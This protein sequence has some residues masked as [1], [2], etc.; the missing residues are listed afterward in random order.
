MSSEPVPHAAVEPAEAEDA[1]VTSRAGK[2]T[3]GAF[4]GYDRLL[5]GFDAGSAGFGVSAYSGYQLNAAWGIEGVIGF[6]SMR[7][8]WIGLLSHA[9][10]DKYVPVGI[11]GR[12]TIGSGI[13]KLILSSHVGVS[14]YYLNIEP[15]G[16][17]VE[18]PVFL[19]ASAGVDF[20]IAK[21][22]D[23]GVSVCG[24]ISHDDFMT[25]GAD[26]RIKL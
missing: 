3:F 12:W 21:W 20:A 7:G 26:V 25:V 8:T 10:T 14:Y 2:V 22:L 24:E 11:G 6:H 13:A 15:Y 5:S 1:R 9:T 19:D 23:V 18:W 17:S 4:G 16:P